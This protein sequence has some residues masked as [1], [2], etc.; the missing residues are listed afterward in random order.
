MLEEEAADLGRPDFVADL[1]KIR[2]AGTHLLGVIS[3]ILDLS[4][5]EAGKMELY[6][7][8]FDVAD[9]VRGVAD[10]ATPLA[11][12]GGSVLRVAAGEGLG[13]MRADLT[14]VR[15]CLLNLLSNACKFTHGGVVTLE[16]SR[17]GDRLTFRVTDSGIGM[18]PAQ[19]GNLFQAFTQADASTTRKYGGTGLGLA[20][21]RRFC[22]MMGGDVQVH[23]E[24]SR[25]TTVTV[26]LP[27]EVAERR[28]GARPAPEAP[29]AAPVGTRSER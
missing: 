26:E 4:K 18:T 20:I 11:E 17:A 29:A 7:E 5:I 15:Q 13:A 28:P 1:R 14:K 6:L 22:E 3:D 2:A 25:G 12:K 19:L 24:V 16:V 8:R 23:S 21:T 27:A 10:T 9:L